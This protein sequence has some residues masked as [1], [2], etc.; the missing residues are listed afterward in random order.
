MSGDRISPELRSEILGVLKEAIADGSVEIPR[1][2]LKEQERDRRTL[3]FRV[4]T[5]F[6]MSGA[7]GVS[8]ASFARAFYFHDASWIAWA[9][10]V[11][12]IGGVLI[13]I[14]ALLSHWRARAR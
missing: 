4:G 7:V 6:A 2:K 11:M 9:S 8:T 1:Q 14:S 13:C 3:A 10:L 5:L 12:A